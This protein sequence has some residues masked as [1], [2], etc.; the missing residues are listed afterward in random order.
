MLND[1]AALS[2]EVEIFVGID[3]IHHFRYCETPEIE[4][5]S[6]TMA[7]LWNQDLQRLDPVPCRLES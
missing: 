7:S 4:G 5:S 6:A 1:V 3:D 2:K